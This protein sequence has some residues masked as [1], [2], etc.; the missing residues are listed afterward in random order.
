[1]LDPKAPVSLGLL[2]LSFKT[3]CEIFFD[4]RTPTQREMGSLFERKKPSPLNPGRGSG[5]SEP[6]GLPS[7]LGLEAGSATETRSFFAPTCDRA[8]LHPN[9]RS[10]RSGLD[11]SHEERRSKDFSCFFETG[12]KICDADPVALWGRKFSLQNTG[13]LEIRLPREAGIRPFE[14]DEKTPP[15]GI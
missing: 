14:R 6:Q 10:P 4:S 7:D 8:V 1:M 12:A 15:V 3:R 13:I 2:Q 5:T 9:P 11:F